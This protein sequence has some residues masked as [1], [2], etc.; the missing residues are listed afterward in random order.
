MRSRQGAETRA[1]LQRAKAGD[2]RQPGTHAFWKIVTGIASGRLLLAAAI[3][4]APGCSRSDPNEWTP[5][6]DVDR[7]YVEQQADL[8]ERVMPTVPSDPD[9]R[10]VNLSMGA[11]A[12]LNARRMQVAQT[13]IAEL[14]GIAESHAGDPRY[15][16]AVHDGHELAGRLALAA[17]DVEAAKSHLLAAGMTPG[18][19]VL[20]SFGPNM[21][22]ARNLLA[23]GER[24]VVLSYFAECQVFWPMG[25]AK[26]AEWTLAVQRGETPDFGANLV[27]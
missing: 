22:L 12:A 23:A 17:G 21:T 26:L 14:L 10:E 18:S 13:W 11:K 24:E 4:F 1:S 7:Q 6:S 3:T 19:P 2:D 8:W 5:R 27:Y 25:T 16:T 15:G 20:G 9:M